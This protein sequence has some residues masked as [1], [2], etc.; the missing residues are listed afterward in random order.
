MLS[1]LRVRVR[2]RVYITYY[3][4]ILL[5]ARY[6]YVSKALGIRAFIY[7]L[8]SFLRCLRGRSKYY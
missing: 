1:N 5:R 6:I 4:S 8:I 3:Y 7:S 2:G